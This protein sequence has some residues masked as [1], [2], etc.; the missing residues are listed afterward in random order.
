MVR[1]HLLLSALLFTPLCWGS[2][3]PSYTD[4][5]ALAQEQLVLEHDNLH[6]EVEALNKRDPLD[7][8]AEASPRIAPSTDDLNL[9]LE[10]TTE[11]AS[12]T[13]VLKMDIAPLLKKEAEKSGYA[14]HC[15]E[16]FGL[17]F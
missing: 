1:A 5:L 13:K 10:R 2:D 7:F 16:T 11:G 9:Q 3:G 8:P 6:T 4:C 15:A 12:P 14:K 17:S